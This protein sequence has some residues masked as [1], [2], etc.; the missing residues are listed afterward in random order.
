DL[1]P[2]AKEYLWQRWTDLAEQDRKKYVQASGV[3]DPK[4]IEYLATADPRTLSPQD[5]ELRWH[6]QLYHILEEQVGSD[7]AN[8]VAGAA[9]DQP[10]PE[11]GILGLV[12]RSQNQYYCGLISWIARWNPWTWKYGEQPNFYY[13]GG[14][15]L[16]AIALAL[17]RALLRSVMIIAA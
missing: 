16:V 5:Q 1:S 6:G 8:A 9:P 15:F 13:L 4:K 2:A 7:A 10:L 11:S 3:E 12:V 14:L 17:V